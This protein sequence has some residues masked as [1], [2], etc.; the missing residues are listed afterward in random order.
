[1]LQ[2]SEVLSFLASQSGAKFV[3]VCGVK[4][5]LTERAASSTFDLSG[6][7]VQQ[8]SKAANLRLI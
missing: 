5:V 1:M 6:Q 3:S 8:I 7:P 2:V 4:K